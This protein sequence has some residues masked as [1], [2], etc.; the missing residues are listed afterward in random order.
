MHSLR[1]I[2][3]VIFCSAAHAQTGVG[4]GSAGGGGVQGVWF[5][6]HVQPPSSGPWAQ[7]FSAGSQSKI[8]NSY[9]IAHRFFFDDA[10]HLMLGYDLL[11][12][13]LPQANV[14]RVSF[15]GL[16]IGVLDLP[17][18]GPGHPRADT[19]GQ[20]RRI[21]IAKLPPPRM[22][23]VGDV[24]SVDVWTAP[25]TRQKILDDIHLDSILAYT[26]TRTAAPPGLV[27][28]TAKAKAA[29]MRSGTARQSL[30]QPTG[31]PHDYSPQDAEMRIEQ[32]RLTLN[33]KEQSTFTSG[34]LTAAGPLVW[35]YLPGRGRYVLSLVARPDLDFAKAGDIRAGTVSFTL[36]NDSIKLE[37]Q[38]LIAGPAPYNLYVSH[39]SQWEPTAQAQKGQFAIGTVGVDELIA[40]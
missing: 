32:P 4:V 6:A 17:A 3:A 27:A 33:G 28:E 2:V 40:L 25:D 39:D 34:T 9:L 24:I 18:L 15:L 7:V 5:N 22:S 37:C 23:S 12:E 30:A 13:T 29:A 19:E 26:I 20:W 1:V 14:F 35:F 8:T 31:P 36:G 38:R 16:G 11:I 10:H 21:T